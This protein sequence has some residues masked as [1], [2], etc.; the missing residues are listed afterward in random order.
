MLSRARYFNDEGMI[1]DE[2]EE[3][4][5]HGGYVMRIDGQNSSTRALSFI[6]EL[7]EGKLRDIGLYF[8]TMKRE[9][10]WMDK[11]FKD[12]RHQSYGYLLKD[13]FL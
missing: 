8:S 5:S 9:A 13:I 4:L 3:K 7:Y 1:A 2:G 11:T 6:T 10:G 12:I